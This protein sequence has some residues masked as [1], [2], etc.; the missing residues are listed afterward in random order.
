MERKVFIVSGGYTE[1]YEQLRRA[2]IGEPEVEIFYDRRDPESQKQRG[3]A[4]VWSGGTLPGGGDRRTPSHVDFDLRVRGWAVI[5]GRADPG[6]EISLTP[7]RP[8]PEHHREGALRHRTQTR[9]R[10]FIGAGLSFSAAAVLVLLNVAAFIIIIIA[11]YALR[12]R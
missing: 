4:S 2:L 10:S 3:K 12:L 7:A 11:L 6:R 1:I 9:P 5:G 8:T